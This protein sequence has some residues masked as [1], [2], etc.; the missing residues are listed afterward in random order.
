M[1]WLVSIR[2]LRVTCLKFFFQ[3]FFSFMHKPRSDPMVTSI[4][5][6]VLGTKNLQKFSRNTVIQIKA[7]SMLAWYELLGNNVDELA[8]LRKHATLRF[9]RIIPSSKH[10]ISFP[11]FYG[12]SDTCKIYVLDDAL[13]SFFF[14][15]EKSYRIVLL[16]DG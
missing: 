15:K 16:D 7:C 2:I 1:V 3:Q 14:Q 8:L 6:K 12:N 9:L 10:G 5:M 4:Y 11:D 13:M